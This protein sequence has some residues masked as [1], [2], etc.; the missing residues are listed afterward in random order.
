MITRIDYAGF[1]KERLVLHFGAVDQA[2]RV[3]VNGVCV[4]EH[5]GGYL[6]FALDVTNA[7]RE[8]ENEVTVTV[9]D[10]FELTDADTPESLEMLKKLLK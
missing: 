5:E 3:S 9:S 7:W 8:G 10:P 2:C 6:P 1:A 4:G